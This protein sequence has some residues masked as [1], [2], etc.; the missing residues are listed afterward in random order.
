MFA[1][2]FQN[3]LDGRLLDDFRLYRIIPR[4]VDNR[5]GLNDGFRHD[6]G[7]NRLG[8]RHRGW[9][10]SNNRSNGRRR[11]RC[12]CRRDYRRNNRRGSH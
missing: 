11:D 3:R 6:H 4:Q 7:C 10:W 2:R 12:N 1:S 8:F 5:Y 9:D